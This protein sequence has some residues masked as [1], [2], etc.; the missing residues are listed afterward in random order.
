MGQEL[1]FKAAPMGMGKTA[2]ARH[3]QHHGDG[4]RSRRFK[5]QCP[6]R[7]D[8]R[9]RPEVAVS[10]I[11]QWLASLGM[12]EYTERFAK[13][14]IDFDVLGDLTDQ[15][16]DRLGVSRGHRRRMLKA[17]WESGGSALATPQIDT[18]GPASAQVNAERR[19]ITVMFCDLVGSTEL[20][21]SSSDDL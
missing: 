10:T 13:D 1:A 14:D 19:Q 8:G 21:D 3:P 12:A 2:D 17:I 15:D 18:A 7:F 11:A 6:V 4:L 20:S 16:F 9:D 5:Y